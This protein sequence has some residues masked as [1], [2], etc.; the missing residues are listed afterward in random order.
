MET[1]L[2]EAISAHRQLEQTIFDMKAMD[3]VRET[4]KEELT[5]A[6]LS[7]N[8]SMKNANDEREQMQHELSLLE[9]QLQQETLMKTEL[10]QQ[11]R[12]A[13]RLLKIAQDGLDREIQ[14]CKDLEAQLVTH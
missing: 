7:L 9:N 8:I 4:E 12:E 10:E 3:E 1:E 6:L 5:K 13:G 2:Q 14:T 11:C